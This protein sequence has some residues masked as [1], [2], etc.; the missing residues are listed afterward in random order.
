MSRPTRKATKGIIATT[1][2]KRRGD[3]YYL[4]AFLWRT[5]GEM[6]RVLSLRDGAYG[7]HHPMPYREIINDRGRAIDRWAGP[8]LGEIHVVRNN[9]NMEVVSHEIAHA[10]IHRL[11]A[12]ALS[13][14]DLDMDKEEEP[15]CYAA[16][17]WADQ[18][19]RWLWK[20]N[21]S[22]KWRRR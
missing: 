21:P 16:G 12:T 11:R 13:K 9:W 3:R 22:K 10:V 19:Y 1:R 17:T 5:A 4:D 6:R 2:L 14:K 8:K 18:L 7:C 20:R 15:I